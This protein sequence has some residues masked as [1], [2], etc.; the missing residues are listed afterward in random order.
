M[1]DM[2]IK[3]VIWF[4]AFIIF[5]TACVM[6][7]IDNKFDAQAAEMEVTTETENVT[8]APAPTPTVPHEPDFVKYIAEIQS[9][10]KEWTYTPRVTE[11]E[12]GKVITE[13]T[14]YR[15]KI[16]GLPER[17]P[18]D[19]RIK[20][21]RV[22]SEEC[23]K[24]DELI[25]QYT[26]D[27]NHLQFWRVRA[28]EYPAATQVWLYMKDLG[29][30]DYVCAGIMGNMMAECGGQTLD[31]D[32]RLYDHTGW[33]YGICQWSM[34]YFPEA[35]DLE[36]EQQL[37]YL[38]DTIEGEFDYAG[39]CYYS[40]FTYEDFLEMTN[41]RD[42]ALAFAKVYERCGSGSYS[43]RQR[44]AEVAYEYFVEN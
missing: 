40:G 12:L 26:A 6:M 27:A 31:I 1:R 43:I 36:L 8:A 29:W 10:F 28:E 2:K 14:I 34:Y 4:A 41:C 16:S 21:V 32:W 30:S 9:E 19:C 44:N 20:L 11:E 7:F 25:A 18:E 5:V 37:D 39:F 22:V 23:A 42:I 13:L 3:T 17:Y 38:R 35:R 15:T 24:I 33:F